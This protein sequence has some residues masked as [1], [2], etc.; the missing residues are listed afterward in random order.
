MRGF[1]PTFP[2]PSSVQ[3]LNLQID[4][5][6]GSAKPVWVRL[7]EYAGL[8]HFTPLQSM[9]LEEKLDA[10][11]PALQKELDTFPNLAG[12]IL[13]PAVLWAGD[14]PSNSKRE[15]FKRS[16]SIAV[17]CPIPGHRV[18]ETIIVSQAGLHEM[19]TDI[20]ADWYAHEDSWLN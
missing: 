12:I 5:V 16:G 20:F 3:A 4:G 1:P 8:W 17:R 9:T 2:G 15:S 10:L 11:G 7:D 14:N 6:E 19:D 18:R 13:S